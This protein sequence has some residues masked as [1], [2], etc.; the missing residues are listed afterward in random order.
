MSTKRIL[1]SVQKIGK[2]EPIANAEAIEKAAVLG[3]SVVVKNSE[4]KIG[5]LCVYIEIDSI[6]PSKP[7]FSFLEKNKFRIRTIRL[8]GQISQGICFPLSIL[9]AGNYSVGQDVTE[10][11]GIIKYEAPI[12]AHLTG[13]IIGPFPTFIPKTDETRIQ[14]CPQILSRHQDK[15]FYVTEKVDGTS[16]TVFVKD[17]NL[18][19]CS[20]KLCLAKDAGNTLWKISESLDLEKKL[21]DSGQKYA[22]QG[23]LVGEDI[24]QNVLKIKGQKLFI[25]NVYDFIN[26]SYLDWESA[27]R[28]VSSWNLETVPMVNEAYRLPQTVDEIVDF[29]IRKS[30]V[31]PAAWSEGLVFRPKTE[32]YDEDLGRLSFKVVNPEFLLH[33][34]E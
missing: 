5:G 32:T 7:E 25:F 14:S 6:L 24:Q 19:V 30:I 11:L 3:W 27:K 4:F 28:T 21:K 17:E 34:G 15:E 1:A 18:Y 16:M 20:R 13:K 12:P 23:E 33:S 26:G 31:N 22:L 29:A 9:P 2:L 10:T 8:R